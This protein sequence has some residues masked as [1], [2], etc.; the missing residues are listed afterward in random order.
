MPSG[1][2]PRTENQLKVAK[3]NLAEGRKPR[4]RNKA[5]QTLK[6]IAKNPEWRHKV[7]SA[8]KLAMHSP[9]VRKKHLKG[10]E[11]ARKKH[12]VNFRGGNGQEPT[13]IVKLAARL[14]SQCGYLREYPIRT[15]PVKSKFKNIP[16][17]YKADFANPEE[18]IVIELDG[19][20]HSSMAQKKKDL[21]KTKVLTA[22]GWTV[23]RLHH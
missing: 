17:S 16:D 7:S 8:V 4:A 1:V 19:V 9:K 3:H 23:I 22:L 12:G 10:L 2:Y 5:R 6:E 13:K 20:C 14:L 11:K 21:K 15:K 18:K